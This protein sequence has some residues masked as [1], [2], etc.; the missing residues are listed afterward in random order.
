MWSAWSK[1]QTRNNSIL[2]PISPKKKNNNN[3]KAFNCADK[4]LY[5]GYLEYRD[6]WPKKR[7]HLRRYIYFLHMTWEFTKEYV[8]ISVY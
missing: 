8:I 1:L 6:K 7:G 4:P 2:P 3:N 5:N